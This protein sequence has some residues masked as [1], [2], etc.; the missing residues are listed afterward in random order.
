MMLLSKL[1][2]K[3]LK[4]EIVDLSQL[5]QEI[6]DKLRQS[7]PVRVA[8]IQIRT[9]VSARADRQLLQIALT[10]LLS[11][12]WKFTAK[13]SSAQIEFGTEEKDGRKVYFIKD[14]GAGFDMQF[15]DRLF[16][17]FQR[18]HSIEE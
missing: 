7:E 4:L 13:V 17:V 5:A 11:N 8:N 10:N 15:A 12:A 2:R 14:N 1:T 9:G 16:G 3:E 6:A 18:F